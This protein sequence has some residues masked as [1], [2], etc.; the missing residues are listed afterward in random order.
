MVSAASVLASV[1]SANG[2]IC[3]VGLL[4]STHINAPALP[5][6]V[7]ASFTGMTCNSNSTGLAPLILYARCSTPCA[8]VCGTTEIP[9]LKLASLN[10]R[11][12]LDIVAKSVSYS[13]PAFG[14]RETK[15][16][17][18]IRPS[19]KAPSTSRFT[20]CAVSSMST[21]EFAA[22]TATDT[23]PNPTASDGSFAVSVT[24]S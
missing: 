21:Q 11:L 2:R 9:P 17:L 5:S 20:S 22:V 10:G 7:G 4:S 24:V 12:R 13:P 23:N 6:T 16:P 19:S 18:L 14:V 1:R 3:V 15:T 8:F